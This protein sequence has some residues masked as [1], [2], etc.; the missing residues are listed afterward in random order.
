[1]GIM[2]AAAD[3]SYWMA[4]MPKQGYAAFNSNPA[5]Y[6]VWRNVKDYGAKGEY[7]SIYSEIP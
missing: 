4:Q 1:M 5:A 2:A 3:A 6:K 7:R